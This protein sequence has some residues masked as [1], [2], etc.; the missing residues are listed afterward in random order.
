[1]YCLKIL[2][3]NF[4]KADWHSFSFLWVNTAK[5]KVE[6]KSKK[7]KKKKKILVFKH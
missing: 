6:I 2:Y 5:Q 4:N 3:E 7:K 1:M